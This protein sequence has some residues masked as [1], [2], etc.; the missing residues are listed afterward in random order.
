LLILQVGVFDT[1][2]HQTMP[3]KAYMYGIPYDYYTQHKVR[4]AL[5]LLLLPQLLHSMFTVSCRSS[6]SSRIST[7]AHDELES[8]APAVSYAA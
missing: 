8:T 3:P 1:A 4:Q 6:I 2:F 7:A 5:L